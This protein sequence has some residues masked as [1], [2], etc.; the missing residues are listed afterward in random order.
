MNYPRFPDYRNARPKYLER[1]WDK[2]NWAFVAA[3]NAG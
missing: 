2:I 3:N 1:M